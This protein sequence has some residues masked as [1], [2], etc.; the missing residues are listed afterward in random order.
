MYQ[1]ICH[2]KELLDDIAY[3]TTVWGMVK[4]IT[5]LTIKLTPPSWQSVTVIS[6]MTD[7]QAL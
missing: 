7:I 2:L 5:Q 4:G 3:E 1:Y 6:K